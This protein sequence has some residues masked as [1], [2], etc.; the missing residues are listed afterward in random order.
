MNIHF[1][2]FFNVGAMKSQMKGELRGSKREKR[3]TR[4]KGVKCMAK[5]NCVVSRGGF[6]GGGGVS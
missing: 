2:L 1:F 4:R 6:L 5:F 3:R